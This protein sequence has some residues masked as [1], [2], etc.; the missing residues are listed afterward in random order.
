MKSRKLE[1]LLYF[2]LNYIESRSALLQGK[3]WGVSTFNLEVKTAAELLETPPAYVLMWVETKA[4]TPKR[5]W[6]NL[7]KL[8]LLCSSL[9]KKT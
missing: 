9:R 1:N 5:S 3:G 2:V 7:G 6:Q 8:K 4:T